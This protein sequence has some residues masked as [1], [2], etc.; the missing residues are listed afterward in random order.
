M[1]KKFT[2][3]SCPTCGSPRTVVNGLWLREQRESAGLSLRAMGAR[4]NFSAVYLGDVELGRR[5]C[6]PVIRA[7]YEALDGGS[8]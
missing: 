6:T 5:N 4:L 2:H 3:G 8:R 1:A 7:G